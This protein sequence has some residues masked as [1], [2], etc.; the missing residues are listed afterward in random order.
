[1]IFSQIL[2]SEFD[3]V[4][5]ANSEAAG[6]RKYADQFNAMLSEYLEESYP[7]DTWGLKLTLSKDGLGADID[8]PFGK[9]RAVIAVRLAEGK[10]QARYIFEK[11][12]IIDNGA[13]IYRPVWA[14][15]V[16]QDGQVLSDD[17]EVQILSLHD[18]SPQ[19][20]K[21][22]LTTIALSALYAIAKDPGY[23]PTATPT[24]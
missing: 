4:R 16:S 7:Q 14:V 11:L 8:S 1:M 13:A 10:I 3:Q 6:V 5:Y 22:G 18:R 2:E 15:L 23:A 12:V 24:T 17:R 9:A 21:N 20:Q 19:K